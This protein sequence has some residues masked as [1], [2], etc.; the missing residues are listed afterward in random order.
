M[1]SCVQSVNSKF[2]LSALIVSVFQT[3]EEIGILGIRVKYPELM[4][5]LSICTGTVCKGTV[6][7]N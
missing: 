4:A 1:D 5:L 3:P 7:T 6:D 2:E